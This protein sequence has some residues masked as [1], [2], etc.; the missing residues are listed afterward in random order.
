MQQKKATEGNDEKN[1]VDAD[2][3]NGNIF[4]NWKRKQI[5]EEN[6][7]ENYVK[8]SIIHSNS[9]GLPIQTMWLLS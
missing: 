2:F 7:Y 1:G 5:E 9:C 8:I 6:I 3:D 4:F